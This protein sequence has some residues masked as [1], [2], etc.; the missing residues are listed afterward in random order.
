VESVVQNY[1][2]DRGMAWIRATRRFDDIDDSI[3]MGPATFWLA[4]RSICGARDA[5]YAVS[6]ANAD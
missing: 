1:S 3:L 5:D 2:A 6:G 4:P